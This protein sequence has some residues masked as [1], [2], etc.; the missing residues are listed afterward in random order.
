M[1]ADVL[2]LVGVLVVGFGPLVAAIALY[3]SDADPHAALQAQA[4][5]LPDDVNTEALFERLPD[6]GDAEAAGDTAGDVAGDLRERAEAL[7]WDEWRATA[8]A[9]G[10]AAGVAL[11][12]AF[13]VTASFIGGW[14]AWLSGLATLLVPGAWRLWRALAM[15]SV[16]NMQ[17]SSGADA[18]SLTHLPNGKVTVEPVTWQHG[19]IEDQQKAGWTPL[20]REK[21]WN[22]GAEGRG[23]ERMGKADVILADEDSTQKGSWVEANFAEALDLPGRT[24]GLYRDATLVANQIQLDAGGGNASNG[25]MADGGTIPVGQMSVE[26]PGVLEDALV[27]IGGGED[28]DGV[29]V[30]ARKIKETYQEKVGSEELHEAEERSY[31]AGI[32]DSGTDSKNVVWLFVAAAV[33]A[34]ALAYGP[35]IIAAIFGGGGGGGVTLPGV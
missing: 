26:D 35:D 7:P 17:N 29:V 21:V 8:G 32:I 22:P 30:S 18:V 25:A 13:S 5:R 19:D 24:D 15:W 12:R 1:V 4:D 20:H 11:V 3:Q 2:I 34:F 6:R 33:T 9:A 14:I 27:E 23:V 16:T 28:H 10:G 31:L